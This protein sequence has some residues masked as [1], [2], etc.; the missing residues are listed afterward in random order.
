MSSEKWRPICVGLNVS[1]LLTSSLNIPGITIA[2]LC[3]A[4]DIFI[5]SEWLAYETHICI[6]QQQMHDG[7]IAITIIPSNMYSPLRVLQYKGWWLT[8]AIGWADTNWNDLE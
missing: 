4:V 7:S 8:Q 5:Y 2:I 3:G 1:K 6:C